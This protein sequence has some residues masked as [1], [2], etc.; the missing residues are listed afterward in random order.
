[1]ALDST[2]RHILSLLQADGKI[3]FQDLGQA[4]GLSPAAA[5]QRVKRLEQRGIVAGYHAL[6]DAQ[7]VGRGLLAFVR[8]LPGPQTSA[9]TLHEGWRA[10]PEVLECHRLTGD[11]GYLLKLRVRDGSTLSRFLDAAR[12]SG[13]RARAEIRLETLFERWTVALGG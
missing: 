1:M 7:A 9:Q 11:D 4:V 8:V 12:A 10:S 5:F 6:V 13:C 3:S 2:D